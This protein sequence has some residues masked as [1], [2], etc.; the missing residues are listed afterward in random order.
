MTKDRQKEIE[1]IFV[2]LC[3]DE[4]DQTY[5]KHMAPQKGT[6]FGG[7]GMAFYIPGVNI[8][9]ERNADTA[10]RV[11]E[12]AEKK[13]IN[14]GYMH[15][16]EQVMLPKRGQIKVGRKKDDPAL[17][18]LVG[19]DAADMDSVPH[20]F[21]VIARYLKDALGVNPDFRGW[22]VPKGIADPLVLTDDDSGIW[23]VILPNRGGGNG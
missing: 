16:A 17:L 23:G 15:D 4:P 21:S 5:L 7:L 9:R 6:F 10:G 22:R 1:Q 19:Q 13:W 18:R 20:P 12:M 14:D 11:L 8:G 3:V 2:K